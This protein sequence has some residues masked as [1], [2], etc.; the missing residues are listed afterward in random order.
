MMRLFLLAILFS[1]TTGES[2]TSVGV[3]RQ[4]QEFLSPPT[5]HL[6]GL[7]K[8]KKRVLENN[9]WGASDYNNG[10]DHY[11][12]NNGGDGGNSNY[13]WAKDDDDDDDTYNGSANDDGSG[14]SY[15]EAN[16]SISSKN[17]TDNN[18][19]YKGGSYVQGNGNSNNRN[20]Y[21]VDQNNDDN[22]D[23]GKEDD[24]ESKFHQIMFGQL[25]PAETII[26]SVTLGVVLFS[27][28]VCFLFG[29]YLLDSVKRCYGLKKKSEEPLDVETSFTELG[30]F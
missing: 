26:L 27:F 17:Y 20:P 25:S 7:G 15:Y 10:D 29:S 30:D 16:K 3:E 8:N 5:E 6:R 22:D 13:V 18:N 19:D 21:N 9:Y 14:S 4:R 28:L 12:S 2:Q 23:N 24:K 1:S 11:S